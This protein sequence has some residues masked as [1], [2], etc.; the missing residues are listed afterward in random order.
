MK[1]S[2]KSSARINL[3]ISFEHSVDV[4]ARYMYAIENEY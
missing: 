1:V 2:Y 4:V 3:E